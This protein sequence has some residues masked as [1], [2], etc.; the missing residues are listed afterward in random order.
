MT[1]NNPQT[2]KSATHTISIFPRPRHGPIQI[3]I[4]LYQLWM[5][6]GWGKC[7]KRQISS[8]FMRKLRAGGC[9]WVGEW[10]TEWAS[11]R[12]LACCWPTQTGGQRSCV[13]DSLQSTEKPSGKTATAPPQL[14]SSSDTFQHS[15]HLIV[16]GKD[17]LNPTRSL[18]SHSYPS[19]FL[20]HSDVS[21]SISSFWAVFV[22][23]P[24]PSPF[25]PLSFSVCLSV[26]QRS[27]LSVHLHF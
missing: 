16:L 14:P 6:W 17:S 20:L 4:P 1:E 22:S 23:P 10:V 2:K 19:C 21:L 15:V 27:Q 5:S 7:L 11:E 3:H 18:L 8:P 26:C 13:T 25:I 12:G 9:E 24:S